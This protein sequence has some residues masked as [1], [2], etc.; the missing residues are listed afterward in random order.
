MQLQNCDLTLGKSIRIYFKLRFQLG[1]APQNLDNVT[2]CHF[3]RLLTKVPVWSGR[4]GA[5]RR[6]HLRYWSSVTPRHQ[7]VQTCDPMVWYLGEDPCEP[8][9][10]INFVEFGGLNEGIGD[11]RSLS[12]ALGAHKEEILRPKATQRIERSAE[13][14]SSSN[15]P[16]VRYPRIFFIR[17]RA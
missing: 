12:T 17:P 1:I 4:F 15:E 6:V 13:V 8:G 9:F 11:G 14:L 3:L 7:L 16:L 10:R 5:D 2:I